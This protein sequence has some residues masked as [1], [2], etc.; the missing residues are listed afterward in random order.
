LDAS[1][2]CDLFSQDRWCNLFRRG[3]FARSND[4]HGL[5]QI[6]SLG[7]GRRCCQNTKRNCHQK[8][9]SNHQ[10]SWKA[11][12]RKPDAC[13]NPATFESSRMSWSQ[14]IRLAGR[15]PTVTESA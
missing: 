5:R 2:T 11:D 8:N 12:Y 9:E 10:S 6:D 13:S 15:K 1:T 14:H 7:L 4:D 3:K